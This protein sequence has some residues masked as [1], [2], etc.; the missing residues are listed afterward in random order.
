MNSELHKKHQ[1]VTFPPSLV[2]MFTEI[3]NEDKTT[4]KVF[5]FIGKT[6]NNQKKVQNH[7]QG[8]TVNDIVENVKVERRE[9][10]QKG[11][12]FTY[13]QVNT[14]ID[15]KAAER[16]VDKLLDMSLLYY[17]PIKPYKFLYMTNRGW[18]ITEE[19]INRLKGAEITNG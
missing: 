12:S 6:L 13:Q 4:R 1:N 14:N 17:T 11:K 10:V 7:I 9:K 8:V 19:M 5:I 18:Q 15:R 3:I 2:E 16:I